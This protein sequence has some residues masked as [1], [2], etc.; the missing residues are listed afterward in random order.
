MSVEEVRN[1][2]S[3]VADIGA[4]YV[5][6]ALSRGSALGPIRQRRVAELHSGGDN[7]IA[8]DLVE[9]MR[10]AIVAGFDHEPAQVAAAGIG[11]CATVD[12]GG[13]LQPPLPSGVPGGRRIG[14]IVGAA[15][16]VPVAVDNDAN[17][18][19]LG[20]LR[21]GA[22][23]GL[24][25][26]VL[27]T[28]GTNI[29]MGLVAGGRVL[30]GAHGG[31][32]EGGMILVPAR[33]PAQPEDELGRRLVDVGRFGAHP[34]QAP[35]GYAWVEELVGGGAL[36][37]ALSERRGAAGTQGARPEAPLRVLAE[38]AAGDR[39]ALSVVDRAIEGWAYI[40]ANSV[41]LFD[42]A[43]IILSGGL[44]EEIGPFL[45]PLRQRV[46]ELSRAEPLVLK[47]EL[48]AVGGLIGASTAALALLHASVGGEQAIPD[49]REP[50]GNESAT[51][52]ARPRPSAA[53]QD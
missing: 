46:A 45:E 27:I 40:I 7:G 35:E 9:L 51:T 48:G 4:T 47:A 31:A 23:R 17:M 12:D 5:R 39:D 16:G 26:F 44:A 25:D 33:S 18:A 10:D 20:E 28:L 22:G 41:A 30:R 53:R 21:H 11:V 2:T 52:A 50:T 13:S 32:G 8:S 49:A 43:A 6:V 14:D 37:R 1:L 3:V 38:A 15:L 19:A 34:S 36:A 42:P 29:G 24:R